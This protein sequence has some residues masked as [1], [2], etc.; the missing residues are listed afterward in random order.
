[1][2]LTFIKPT[3]PE[4]EGAL[5]HQTVVIVPDHKFPTLNPS[6][7]YLLGMGDHIF[8]CADHR[9]VGRLD[10]NHRTQFLLSYEGIELRRTS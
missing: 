8:K 7:T 2:R 4:V 3:V 9:F 1:M 5:C 10:M 6:R